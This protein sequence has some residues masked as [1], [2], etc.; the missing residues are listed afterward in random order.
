[1]SLTVLN[2]PVRGVIAEPSF[3]SLSGLEQ[4][5]AYLQGRVP[6]T[7]HS[8]LLGYRLTQASSGTVAFNQPIS[9]W[10]DVYDGFVDLTATAEMSTFAAAMTVAPAG[11]YVRTANMSLRYLRPCT[12]DS[13]SVIARGRILHAGSNVTTV[14]TLIED[15]LGRAVAQAT[16]STVLEVM[17]P[18]PAPHTQ[19]LEPVEEPIY[20]SPDPSRR[21]FPSAETIHA[22]DSPLS[23]FLGA[24][25]VGTSP[26]RATV[27]MPTSEWFCNAYREVTPGILG[28][29]GSVVSRGITDQLVDENER[30]VTINLTYSFPAPV[31]PDGRRLEAV[32][33]L[34]GRR[35]E[36]AILDLE[37][38]DAD[39]RI[40]LL[41]QGTGLVRE[42]TTRPG[43]RAAE[44]LL[45]TV[46]FT[47][48][49]GSTEQ[50][51]QLGDTRWRA[52]LDE[53]HALVRRA[54]DLH[55]GRE[56]KTTG[57]GFLATFDS[58]TRAV[59]CA[60]DI[61]DGLERLDLKIRAG[62]HTGECDL[63][64]GGDVGGVAVHASS[65]IESAAEP[66]EILVSSTVRDL[67]AGSGLT[68]IDR[69]VKELKGLEGE[70]TLFAVE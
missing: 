68:L 48:L 43:Q 37:I 17:D 23:R 16:G 62:I 57:D 63:V 10:F 70:W 47:D 66:G 22:P 7:P 21:P 15:A 35:N 29:L 42:K 31:P 13:E 50:A 67:V 46:L 41:A 12:V 65:R 49:V 58:P 40:V 11:T 33:T 54:L 8:H 61:R 18:P 32:A 55:K 38:F 25:F 44:R 59:R 27:T 36:M 3:R 64:A 19:L 4:L 6:A 52:R 45:L 34:R 24:D 20:S 30:F 39:G 5:R 1:M 2:E 51:V 26:G 69:G 28:A 56:V 9:P 53:H 60:R 14:E